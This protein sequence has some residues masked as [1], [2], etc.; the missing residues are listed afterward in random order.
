[1]EFGSILFHK[2]P[3]SFTDEEC[4]EIIE[5]LRKTVESYGLEFDE[6][7]FAGFDLEQTPIQKC[8]RC[9]DLTLDM[10]T[11]KEKMESGDI[12]DSINRFLQLGEC[13]D[14]KYL[15]FECQKWMNTK[16]QV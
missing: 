6:Y 8:V 16:Y 11:R 13:K 7:Q 3:A 10:N 9:G 2:F 1:M 4:E 12:F 5:A 15:C 14:G